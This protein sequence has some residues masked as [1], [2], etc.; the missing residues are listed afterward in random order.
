VIDF[1]AIAIGMH[2][3]TIHL[4]RNRDYNERNLGVYARAERWQ[5][6]GYHNSH[7]KFS[8]YSAYAYAMTDRV[9]AHVG[10]ATGYNSTVVPVLVFTYR[11]DN[12]LRIGLIPSSPKGGSGG[13][14]FAYQWAVK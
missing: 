12:G 1:G 7:R 13:I 9:E 8:A 11:L 10:L 14:H 3:G 4:N 6:G 2:I 5:V